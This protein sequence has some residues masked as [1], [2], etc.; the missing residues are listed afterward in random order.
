MIQKSLFFALMTMLFLTAWAPA[1]ADSKRVL[2]LQSYHAEY[3]WVRDVNQGIREALEEERFMEG[4]NLTLTT[5]YM[6]TKRHTD[7]AWKQK[8]ARE[9][10]TLI[11]TLS[12]G[13]VIASDD[14]AQRH[15]VSHLTDTPW[16]V[17]FTGVNAEP[18]GYGFVDSLTA[19]GH[20]VTGCLERERFKGSIRLLKRVVPGASRI[21]VI[22]DDGPTSRPILNRIKAQADAADVTI[23]G[24]MAATTFDEWQR[25]VL[26]MQTQADALVVITYHVVK[27]NIGEEVAPEDVLRWTLENNRLPE[28]GFWKWAVEDG[29]LLSEA[30]SGFQ[31]GYHAGTLA[32]F[33]LEG[34]APGEFAV[35]TPRRGE[36]CINLAR[37]KSLGLAI[38]ADLQT[39]TTLFTDQRVLK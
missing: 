39:F 4:E 17:V 23:T 27:N 31:Q 25:F 21:A 3:P 36:R 37:A 38:P 32:A 7:A 15:V 9:A 13:V 30:I 12:P 34:Q 14:N 11:D 16:P 8:K 6:D 22:S 26:E 5:F 10:L 1:S 33:I 2:I 29:L 35:T 20:N 24:I 19:P 28:V 18:T